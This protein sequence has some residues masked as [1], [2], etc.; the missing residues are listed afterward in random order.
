VSVGP[1]RFR[2]PAVLRQLIE[3]LPAVVFELRRGGR[4]RDMYFTYVSPQC[5]VVTGHAAEDV[6]ADVGL[7][8]RSLHPDDREAVVAEVVRASGE[9]DR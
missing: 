3:Q 9:L 4:P 1:E 5:A 6:M 8:G 7:F 2:D